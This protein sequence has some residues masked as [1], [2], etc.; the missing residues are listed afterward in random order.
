MKAEMDL[1]LQ[2]LKLQLEAQKKWS[3]HGKAIFQNTQL[4]M[5]LADG[6]KSDVEVYATSEVIRLEGRVICTSLIA[7]SYAKG[8]QTFLGMNFLHKV[9][10]VLNLK[11][12]LL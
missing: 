4:S 8:K 5:S 1:E 12:V 7:L 2:K 11:L 3:S 6:L 10:I 9:G